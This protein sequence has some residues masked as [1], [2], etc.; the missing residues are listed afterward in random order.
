MRVVSSHV[1]DDE[2]VKTDHE[3]GPQDFTVIV[4]QQGLQVDAPECVEV[5]STDTIACV[6]N[7]SQAQWEWISQGK[8]FLHL[9]GKAFDP[10]DFSPP[11]KKVDILK[12]ID[13]GMQHIAGMIILGCEACMAGK[14][15]FFRNPETYL[16]PKTEQHIAGMLREMQSLF[17]GKGGNATKIEEQPPVDESLATI[18]WLN[19]LLAHYGPDKEMFQKEKGKRGT[20]QE[21]IDNVKQNTSI[22][23][24]LVNNF[25]KLRDGS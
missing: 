13:V 22:G 4:H 2:I 18:G 17:N 10:D 5:N 14:N 25:V 3:L 24:Q 11:P 16:H 1:V 6:K 12:L 9:W 15:V 21:A 20:V 8:L 19:A 23:Q 7:L